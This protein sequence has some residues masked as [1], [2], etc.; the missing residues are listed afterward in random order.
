MTLGF[1][2]HWR[3]T[4]AQGGDLRRAGASGLERLPGV[5][6]RVYDVMHSKAYLRRAAQDSLDSLSRASYRR[7]PRRRRSQE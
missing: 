7:R 6:R 2:S 5:Q 1:Y 3:L 4:E